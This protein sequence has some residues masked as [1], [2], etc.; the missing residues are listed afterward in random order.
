MKTKKNCTECLYCKVSMNSTTKCRL[1]FCSVKN[2]EEKHDEKYW[3]L[4]PVCNN[5][6]DMS[7]KDI[8]SRRPLLRMPP[9]S[10]RVIFA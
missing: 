8:I 9:L 10:G 6:F 4:K 5:F 1:C 2:R 7:D 3:K